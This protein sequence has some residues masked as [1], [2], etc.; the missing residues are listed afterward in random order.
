MTPPRIHHG[1]DNKQT[2]W[3]V[4][5]RMRASPAT[6]VHATPMKLCRFNDN[7]LGCVGGDLV[8]DVGAALDVLP[9]LRWPRRPAMPCWHLDAVVAA[10]WLAAGAPRCRLPGAPAR[11]V[12]NRARSWR[13]PPT[14]GFTSGR[15]RDPG[16][17][18]GV[19]RKATRRRERPVE[20]FGLFLKAGSFARR[21][22]RVN[23]P[24][25][26]GRRTDHEV[27][28]AV[29]IGTGRVRHSTRPGR[30]AT[31]RPPHHRPRRPC[32][33][34]RTAA[35]A[36]RRTPTY[37]VLGPWLVTA[38]EIANPHALTMSLWVNGGGNQHGSSA[39]MTVDIPDLIAI[40]SS[41]YTLHP[42]T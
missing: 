9:A 42:A 23:P 21:A 37:A 32:A 25:P 10:G 16:V 20:K 14:T 15:T 6:N 24:D 19:H 30:C 29:V 36:S 5:C 8:R 26:A 38:D 27:E 7:R 35:S 17:D 28:L 2:A 3:S 31:S 1:P 34:P 12:A 18:H 39:A 11:P 22:V 13:H 41:M 40:A 33:A 4:C